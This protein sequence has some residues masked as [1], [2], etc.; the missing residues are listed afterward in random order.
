MHILYKRTLWE[1][2]SL[3]KTTQSNGQRKVLGINVTQL[4]YIIAQKIFKQYD[5]ERLVLLLVNFCS[6]E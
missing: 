4:Y 3:E 1:V 5:T 6:F 2:G